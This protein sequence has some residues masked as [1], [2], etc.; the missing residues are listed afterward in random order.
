[1]HARKEGQCTL[2]AEIH[3]Q[4]CPQKHHPS[5]PIPDSHICGRKRR[6]GG[7]C[8]DL[9]AEKVYCPKVINEHIIIVDQQSQQLG[10]GWISPVCG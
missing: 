1:M 6:L 7:L 10:K 4:S 9:D 5:V 3:C 8:F 2:Q